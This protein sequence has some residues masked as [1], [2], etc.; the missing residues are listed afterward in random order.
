[1]YICKAVINTKCVLSRPI[2]SLTFLQVLFTRETFLFTGFFNILFVKLMEIYFIS[3]IHTLW[4]CNVIV[5]SLTLRF[6][7]NLLYNYY[8]AVLHLS[9]ILWVIL[10]NILWIIVNNCA[11]YI[12]V[13]KPIDVI[14]HNY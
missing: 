10:N 11:L 7:R 12:V 4:Y 3:K 6:K 14:V 2:L 1:M 13:C 8:K 9:N 5:T